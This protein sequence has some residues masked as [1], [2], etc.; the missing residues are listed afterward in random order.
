MGFRQA[1]STRLQ[2]TW[3]IER[4]GNRKSKM[5]TK[6][7]RAK[8]EQRRRKGNEL[9]THYSWRALQAPGSFVPPWNPSSSVS[10]FPL[11]C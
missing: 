4:G 5:R 9:S 6:R 3:R 11:F 2:Q 8:P 1:M 7:E 10:E